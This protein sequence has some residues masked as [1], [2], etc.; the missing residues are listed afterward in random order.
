MNVEERKA[1]LLKLVEEYRERECRRLLEAAREDAAALI[2]Q[3]YRR[4]RAHLHGRI[5]SER[6][7][8]QA[9]IQAARA[10]RATRQRWSSEQA[11]MAL[12]D[13]AWPR[14]RGR[15]AARW[16]DPGGRRAWAERYLAEALA[17]LPK[18]RWQIRHA[19]GWGEHERRDAA[20]V[21]TERLGAAPRFETDGRLEAGLIIECGG[22]VLDAS[23]EGLMRDRRLLEARLLALLRAAEE[24]SGG[25]GA[26]RQRDGAAR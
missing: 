20:A 24:T 1:A 13:A 17:L 10:E 18:G 21:L 11:N 8:A 25:G 3:T 19:G 23:L 4:E 26:D 12:L 16:R 2:G 22:G 6:S 5:V 15:L 7:R 14:L 9:L